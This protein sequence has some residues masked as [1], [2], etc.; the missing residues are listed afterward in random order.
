MPQANSCV[1]SWPFQIP[2]SLVLPFTLTPPASEF[3]PWHTDAYCQ[4]F[5][6]TT[7]FQLIQRVTAHQYKL[8]RVSIF[9]YTEHMQQR[10]LLITFDRGQGYSIGCLLPPPSRFLRCFSPST[11]D[12]DWERHPLFNSTFVSE[13]IT[14]CHFP[15]FRTSPQTRSPLPTMMTLISVAVKIMKHTYS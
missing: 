8:T 12:Q 15:Q 10:W 4:S 2:V 9:I 6:S 3:R 14:L 13:L 11:I 7:F 5:W 1:P